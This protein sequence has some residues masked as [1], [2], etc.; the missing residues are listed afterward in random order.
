MVLGAMASWVV[1]V[2]VVSALQ[3]SRQEPRLT[4]RC[5]VGCLCAAGEPLPMEQMILCVTA[6]RGLHCTAQCSHKQLPA[7]ILDSASPRAAL[8]NSSETCASSGCVSWTCVCEGSSSC[9]RKRQRAQ[10]ASFV[11]SPQVCKACLH[12]AYARLVF[13]RTV[14]ESWPVHGMELRLTPAWNSGAAPCP[15][16]THGLALLDCLL[17]WTSCA[18]AAHVLTSS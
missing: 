6:C 14:E 1:S 7:K 3:E 13:H 5:L 11:M 8:R 12:E 10:R 2:W 16:G 4:A 9:D 18:L 15:H 17:S